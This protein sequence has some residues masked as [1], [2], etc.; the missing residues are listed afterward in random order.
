M[1]TQR[2]SLVHVRTTDAGGVSVEN[3]SEPDSYW[4]TLRRDGEVTAELGI[5]GAGRARRLE[6]RIPRHG[7]SEHGHEPLYAVRAAVGE[8]DPYVEDRLATRLAEQCITASRA[9]AAE[10][11][12]VETHALL[13]A[14]VRRNPH[15]TVGDR[16]PAAASPI[17]RHES[18]GDAILS[19]T[20]TASVPTASLTRA[21][22]QA[23]TQDARVHYGVFTALAAGSGLDADTLADLASKADGALPMLDP[24]SMQRAAEVLRALGRRAHRDIVARAVSPGGRYAWLNALSS[25]AATGRL[26]LTGVGSDAEL[27][28]SRV[29]EALAPEGY[30]CDYAHGLHGRESSVSPWR[31]R[32]LHSEADFR[33]AGANMANCLGSYA[34]VARGRGSIVATVVDERGV[35][36]HAIE[37]S[38]GEVATWE[39]PRRGRPTQTERRA[40]EADLVNAGLVSRGSRADTA[41]TPARRETE[42]G[43]APATTEATPASANDEPG[44]GVEAPLRGHLLPPTPFPAGW[45]NADDLLVVDA[46]NVERVTQELLGR[47]PDR[48]SRFSPAAL[49]RW[50]EST[51]TD[52]PARAVIFTNVRGDD[53]RK[54]GWMDAMVRLGF[55]V[56]ERQSL[57]SGRAADDVDLAMEHAVTAKPW[58]RIVVFSHDAN[59]FHD[60]LE[61][62]TRDGRQVQV[63]GLKRGRLSRAAGVE[64]VDARDIDGMVPP[65][66]RRGADQSVPNLGSPTTAGRWVARRDRS[67]DTDLIDTQATRAAMRVPMSRGVNRSG[68]SPEVS[69]PASEAAPT[70]SERSAGGATRTVEP[71][72]S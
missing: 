27:L 15:L 40:L 61:A 31:W 54:R 26:D 1:T 42:H 28:E 20:G 69:S 18:L 41:S 49:L 65:V 14:A 7:V 72:R 43:S 4:F 45:L 11:L 38:D 51:S 44:D 50:F 21:V 3:R 22:G 46:P 63:V 57:G 64:Y 55:D 48:A 17:L 53:P 67:V 13:A 37:I 62:A 47:M 6:L 58:R 71:R 33:V 23:L 34:G 5:T 25:A 59:R 10:T 68:R 12:I 36:R 32:V 60:V 39:T 9:T 29:I 2:N 66:L 70:R 16:L 35:L 24:A 30:V 8:A 56:F 19:V 52:H